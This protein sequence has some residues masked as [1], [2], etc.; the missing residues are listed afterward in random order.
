MQLQTTSKQ[1]TKRAKRLFRKA[2]LFGKTQPGQGLE[3]RERLS[4]EGKEGNKSVGQ[5]EAHLYP[6]QRAIWLRK[7]TPERLDW[8]KQG[9]RTPAGEMV[10]RL[11]Y[12]SLG[13][14][15]CSS[16]KPRA[17]DVKSGRWE[18]VEQSDLVCSPEA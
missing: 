4:T 9:C 1:L 7:D 13:C 14:S 2:A 11:L 5:Q 15:S 17:L 12:P 16:P 3:H 6:L 8:G 10:V 18:A